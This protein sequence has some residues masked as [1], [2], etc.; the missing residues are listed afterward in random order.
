[1]SYYPLYYG[2][3]SCNLPCSD[4]LVQLVQKVCRRGFTL[5][6]IMIVV[7]IIGTLSA[8][9]VPNYLKYREKGKIVL[10]LTDI[11][12]IEKTISIYGIDTGG[13]PDSLNDLSVNNTIDPWGNPYQY[14][15]IDGGN[16]LP[17]NM[18]KDHFMVPINTDYD[19]LNSKEMRHPKTSVITA[20]SHVAARTPIPPTAFRMPVIKANS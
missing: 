9:A 13:L 10:A 1:M 8:I 5:I 3:G 19:L 18:R 20:R 11:R 2:H 12:I 7:A 6:E 4:N 14:L 15:R 17:G 16:A